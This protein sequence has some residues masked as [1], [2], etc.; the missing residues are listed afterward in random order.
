MAKPFLPADQA[1][2]KIKAGA[3]L[4][5]VRTPKEFDQGHVHGAI[6]IPYDLIPSR[7]GEFPA[8]KAKEIIVYCKSGQRSGVAQEML[9]VA[10]YTQVFN[11]GGY[12]DLKPHF[13]F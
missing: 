11:A 6:L 12:E 2:S 7:L 4:I 13:L 3:I 5:D 9:E 10:G 1:A 8:D